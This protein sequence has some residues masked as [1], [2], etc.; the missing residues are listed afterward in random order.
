MS[1]LNAFSLFTITF[2]LIVN[3]PGNFFQISSNGLFKN[4]L[5]EISYVHPFNINQHEKHFRPEKA[6][7]SK[8]QNEKMI[9]SLLSD[10]LENSK[11]KA[12]QSEIVNNVKFTKTKY[13]IATQTLELN[14]AGNPQNKTDT[15]SDIKWETYIPNK[16]KV[17]LEN[18]ELVKASLF[19]EQASKH[20]KII[21][22]KGS[23]H[24]SQHY[25]NKI[26]MF[27]PREQFNDFQKAANELAKLKS[28][29][30]N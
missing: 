12:L 5:R 28:S 18:S 7:V 1:P 26:L 22:T 20:N 23:K 30:H 24:I 10:I 2:A 25:T 19:F 27:I 29:I 21:V 9:I 3:S 13:I 6:Q 8:D 14:N 11:G 17:E 15:Y 16:L 4:D